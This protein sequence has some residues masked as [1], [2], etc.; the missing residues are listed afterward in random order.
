[1]PAQPFTVHVD[2]DDLAAHDLAAGLFTPT[3]PG[4][5]PRRDTTAATHHGARD[6]RQDARDRSGRSRSN[7]AAPARTYAFRRS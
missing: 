2:A 5:P 4:T 3:T 1:M 6:S 7:R